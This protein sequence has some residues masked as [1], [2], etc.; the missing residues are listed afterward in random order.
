M[1]APNTEIQSNNAD[2]SLTYSFF[3]SLQVYVAIVTNSK[4]LTCQQTEKDV[5]PSKDVSNS[6]TN[7]TTSLGKDY[8]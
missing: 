2:N 1:N 5:L 4:S 8:V 3:T 7:L 6:L